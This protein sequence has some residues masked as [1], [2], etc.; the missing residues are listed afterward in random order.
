[1]RGGG[2]LVRRRWQPLALGEFVLGQVDESNDVF[3]V[4][5]PARL[6]L[7]GTFAAIRGVAHRLGPDRATGTDPHWRRRPVD[8]RS[9]ARRSERRGNLFDEGQGEF[10]QPVTYGDDPFGLRCPITAHVRRANPRDSLGF[11]GLLA[12]RRRLIRRGMP[13]KDVRGGLLFISLQ[14][15]IDDQFE[16]VQREWLNTGDAFGLGRDPDVIAG[17]WSGDRQVVLPNGVGLPALARTEQLS[18]VCGGEY[19]FVPSL[20]GLLY[21]V[22]APFT[23]S[24]A[25]KPAIASA[26]PKP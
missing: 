17:H 10:R 15:R 21:L 1:M 22:C 19:L 14:A 12:H 24:R 18:C 20:R 5:D 9:R 25:K 16:F 8:R 7:G 6:F 26:A 4:P 11:D 3:P 23:D 13:I 2:K